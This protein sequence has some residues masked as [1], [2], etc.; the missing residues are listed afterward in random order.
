M[1]TQ[2]SQSERPKLISIQVNIVT[3]VEVTRCHSDIIYEANIL[4]TQGRANEQYTAP[5]A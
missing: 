4:K 3:A 1:D 2:I 5:G